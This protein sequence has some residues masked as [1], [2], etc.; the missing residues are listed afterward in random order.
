M[1]AKIISFANHKGGVG[2]TTTTANVGSILASKGYKV[3]LVDLDPQANLTYSLLD[4]SKIDGTVHEA[5]TGN[6]ERRTIITTINENLDIVPSS[7][8]LASAD[9]ELA[10]VMAREFIL[11]EWLAPYKGEYD[12]IL[13][14]CPPSLG[15]LTL[16]AVTAS[17]GVVIP[18]TAEYL[19]FVGLT[20]IN[21]FIDMVKKKLNPKVS[22]MGILFTRY[23]KSTMS[24]QIEEG[25]RSQLGDLVFTTKI[26]K[27]VTLAQAPSELRNIV[28]Y[29][30]RSNGAIDYKSFTEEFINR[31]K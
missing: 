3:L 30:A 17:D 11:S 2:K 28:D 19:P 21:N 27:N 23:E 31:V 26:R 18:L 13:I 6:S 9:L 24:R 15:L 8:E 16:N 20:M 10:G 29:D 7:L 25:L 12:Y 1:E 22:V 14:D 5:L 4:P